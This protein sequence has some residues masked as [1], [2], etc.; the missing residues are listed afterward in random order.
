[1]SQRKSLCLQAR[2]EL[3]EEIRL[4]TQVEKARRRG[5]KEIL[6]VDKEKAE[7]RREEEHPDLTEEAAERL[8]RGRRKNLG[9]VKK[10]VRDET[11]LHKR[12]LKEKK[13]K[14]VRLIE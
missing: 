13:K 14:E 2:Y 5:Q 12:P 1:M 10:T 9:T 4:L 11:E 6:C 3:A 8:S 7:K